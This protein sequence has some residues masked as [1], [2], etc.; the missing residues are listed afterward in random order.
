M[1]DLAYWRLW[2]LVKQKSLLGVFYPSLLHIDLWEEMQTERRLEIQKSKLL[3]RCK[4]A[5]CFNLLAK[6]LTIR[7]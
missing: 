1:G 7:V 4:V 5:A 2:L 6:C 3:F